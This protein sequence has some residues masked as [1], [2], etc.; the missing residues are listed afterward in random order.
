MDNK[1]TVV[2][3]DRRH[4]HQAVH[5]LQQAFRDDPLTRLLCPDATLRPDVVRAVFRYNVR[6]A[7]AAGGIYATSLRCEGV[8][9]WMRSTPG[10]RQPVPTP[11]RDIMRVPTGVLH[12]LNDLSQELDQARLS[13]AGNEPHLYLS[14]LGVVPQY[15]RQGLATLL[16]DAV[17]ATAAREGKPV[18]LETLS[19]ENQTFYGKRG[20]STVQVLSLENIQYY[21]M[22]FPSKQ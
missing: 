6:C 4:V 8:T 20:F 1:P 18:W 3:L 16:L 14:T 15:R 12:R 21:I 10:R 22:R 7:L 13:A 11:G 2:T 5:T 17:K 9:L 19:R